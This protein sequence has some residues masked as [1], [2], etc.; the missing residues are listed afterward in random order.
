MRLLDGKRILITGAARGIG[1][2]AATAMREH[3]A[4]VCNADVDETVLNEGVATLG[5]ADADLIPVVMDVCDSDAIRQ[6][7]ERIDGRWSGL[8]VLVNN[9]AITESQDVE[10]VTPQRFRQVLDVNLISA[11]EVTQ[12]ALPLMRTRQ[13]PSVINTASTQAFFG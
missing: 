3:G 8:D 6:T 1:L 4:R 13:H 11:L 12:A 10:E 7:L 9:A 2:A 5:G